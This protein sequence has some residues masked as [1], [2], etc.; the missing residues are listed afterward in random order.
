MGGGGGGNTTTKNV[1]EPWAEQKPYLQAGFEEAGKIYNQGP[2]Q[3]YPGQT[4]SDMS[5][6]TLAGL[7][8][9]T[10][11]ASGPNPLI[12]NASSYVN[13]TL[14]GQG[15]NPWDGILSSGVEGM[16]KTAN[17]DMLTNN[18]YLDQVYGAASSKVKQDF[19]DKVIPGIAA[20]LGT[21]GMAGSTTGDLLG[22]QAGGELTDSLAGLAANIYG[23][24]Y[25]AE[26]DRQTQAQQGLTSAGQGLYGTNVN[27]R[28]AALGQ[29]PGIREA[30]FGDA[31]KLQE[32][33]KA[34]EGQSD[35]VREDDINRFN[36]GQNAD[37]AALQDYLSM[38][39]GNYGSTST[40]RTSGG[41][42]SGLSTGLGAAA[43]I[44]SLFG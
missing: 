9:Q 3:Y 21:S 7:E 30:Q 37:T 41:G 43:S 36:Y 12:G 26:R 22:A 34:Y 38:I 42:G 40:S 1:S 19:S 31:G 15:D 28:L 39:S 14:T 2:S 6:P 5:D 35:K 13:K 16:Q 8:K 10:Q 4:Y 32:A 27:E 24:N 11:L 44:L 23:G 29:A 25:Q 33:G 17:G 18:P 20:G